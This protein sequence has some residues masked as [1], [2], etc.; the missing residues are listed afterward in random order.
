[1]VKMKRSPWFFVL[2][3][4][5]FLQVARTQTVADSSLLNKEFTNLEEALSNPESVFRLNL[6]NQNLQIPDTVWSKFLN[7]EYLSLKN[8]HLKQIPNGIGSLKNLKVLDLSGNDFEV[9]PSSFNNLINLQELY[10][11]DEKYLQFEKSIPVLSKLPK[12][13]SLHLEGDGLQRLPKNFYMLN[14]IETLYLNNNKFKRVPKEINGLKNLKYL[15]VHDNK[16]K[17][18]TDDSQNASHGVKIRF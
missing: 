17:L 14:Q 16:L 6:S 1:M 4:M 8:D 2:A 9:L 3:L 5:F 11:N 7:L 15:D 12:L 13:K 10:L 18:P